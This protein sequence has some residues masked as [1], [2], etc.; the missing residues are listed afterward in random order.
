MSK[1]QFTG[2]ATAN[3]CEGVITCYSLQC[4]R[5]L[6]VSDLWNP[7]CICRCLYD[8]AIH[9]SLTKISAGSMGIPDSSVCL[10]SDG[11]S[12]GARFTKLRKAKRIVTLVY[13]NK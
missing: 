1:N 5:Q 12:P 7:L 10:Q 4:H 9:L 6:T 13:D 2:T 11:T 3:F 8:Y